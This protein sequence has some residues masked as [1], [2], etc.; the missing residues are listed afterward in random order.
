MGIKVAAS[1][2][3]VHLGK[4][5]I[6]KDVGEGG[7]YR[8]YNR[9]KVRKQRGKISADNWNRKVVSAQELRKRYE[10]RGISKKQYLEEI[11]AL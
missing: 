6:Q 5:E 1:N 7:Y 11:N 9:L 10:K 2:R 8:I 4:V 3:H